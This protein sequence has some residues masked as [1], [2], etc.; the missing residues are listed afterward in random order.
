M[1]LAHEIVFSWLEEDNT[2]R[3]YFRLKPLLTVSGDVQEEAAK[4]WPEDGALRIVPDKNEQGYFK[5]RMRA[6]G[7]FCLM[8]L[9]PFPTEANKI[10]T[11]KNF[12]PERDERNQYI[13]YSD[14]VK[15]VPPHTFYEVLEGAPEDAANL[16][17]N[18]ST[19]LFLIRQDDVLYGP[20]DQQ[21]P[22]APEHAP[23]MEAVVYEVA[24]PDGKQRVILCKAGEEKKEE[25][26]EVKTPV[27][28]PAPVQR[29]A[30]MPAPKPETTEETTGALPIGKP[31]TI[32]DESKDFA[33]T[34]EGLN[35]PLSNGANLL[36]HQ[37]EEHTE[38]EQPMPPQQLTGTPLMRSTGLRT[39]VPRPKNHVQEVVAN[40]MRAARND[41]PAAPLPNGVTMR[42]VDNPVERACM[43]LQQAWQMPEA[44]QQL[45]D[46]VLSLPGMS[47]RIVP[48]VASSQGKTPLQLALQHRL[49]DLEAERLAALI[50]LD[51]AKENL[52][53]YRKSALESANGE[54]AKKLRD[55]E[56]KLADYA[57][58]KD[59][60]SEQIQAL[61]AQRDA[62]EA[63][64]ERLRQNDYASAL[65]EALN[66][67]HL[68]TPVAGQALRMHSHVGEPATL[69]EAAE[70]FANAMK[71]N[72]ADCTYNAA[73]A[74]MVAMTV[75]PHVGLATATL[76][77]AA[78]LA[79]NVAYAMGWHA[80]YALQTTTNQTPVPDTEHVDA[81]TPM[82]LASTVVDAG[83]AEPACTLTLVGNARTLTERTSYTVSPYP[84]FTLPALAFV[85]ACTKEGKPLS[86]DALKKEFTAEEL[87]SARSVL[88]PVLKVI[89]P[90]PGKAAKEMEQFALLCAD[91]MEGGLAAA[92][93]WAIK[94]WVMPQVAMN[95]AYKNQLRPL[96]AEYPQSTAM[97]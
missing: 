78:T 67:A 80:G 81:G 63:E 18:A 73:V 53:A 1:D 90:L 69:K 62:V 58:Q 86:L 27:A 50:Q 87:A 19:P 16:A 34:L 45:V 47:A 95:M 4:L 15:A 24:C 8:D 54:M 2:Q 89:P 76:A 13:L 32:L 5:D 93:D 10:R 83:L 21:N 39:S 28:T 49:D 84:I 92:C 70:H 61:G 9:T 66:R 91:A 12:R 14:A 94:L 51:K 40:Q 41:P 6:M 52:E 33:E 75:C 65:A 23:E 20:V 30:P 42:V 68:V 3:A 74:F 57:K 79:E 85:E 82:V 31:L 46:F 7:N 55:A 64:V 88:A 43:Q 35:Q 26:A 17:A 36:H 60:L 29:T 22:V 77:A 71:A 37:R 96:L 44:Q 72:R 97:L 11:N 48:S 25:T 56:D 38:I 59:A